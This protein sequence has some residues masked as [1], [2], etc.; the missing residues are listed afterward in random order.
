MVDTFIQGIPCTIELEY[1]KAF[2]GAREGG[3]PLEPDELAH[4]EIVNIFKRGGG[5]KH[6]AWLEAKMTDE[7]RERIERGQS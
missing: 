6:M 3:L 2:H 1:H 4:S 7:E 5:G